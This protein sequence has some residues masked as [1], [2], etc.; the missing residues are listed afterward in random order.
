MNLKPMLLGLAVFA[1]VVTAI[2]Q[3][4]SDDLPRAPV[5][6]TTPAPDPITPAVR[7]KS[8]KIAQELYAPKPVIKAAPQCPSV[9]KVAH[10]RRVAKHPLTH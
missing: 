1:F 4:T 6:E 3:H 2:V 9:A 10:K 5:V 8:I 7:E